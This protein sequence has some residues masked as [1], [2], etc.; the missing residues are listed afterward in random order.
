[1]QPKQ[2]D[3][4]TSLRFLAAASVVVAHMMGS[5]VPPFFSGAPLALGVSFFFVLSGF[6][7]TYAYQGRFDARR[8]Y[9]S[10]FARLWPVHIVTGLLAFVLLSPFLAKHPEWLAPSIANVLLLHAWVPVVGYVFSHNAVS[11]SI[12]AEMF[13]YLL[14]PV[15]RGR[16]L[17]L[18][19]AAT[20]LGTATTLA[21]LDTVPIPQGQPNIWSF[22]P[23]NLVLQHPV[24][25]LLEFLVGI[26]TC[27]LYLSSRNDVPF[28]TIAEAGALISILLFGISSNGIAA[29]LTRYGWRH[30]GMWISQTGGML[31]FA[32]TIFIFAHQRGR[33]SVLLKHRTIVWLGEISFCTY[34]A[35]QIII[36]L[37]VKYSVSDR[38]GWIPASVL[39]LA[40]VYAASH[41][42]WRYWELPARLRILELTKVR[43]A[44]T[45]SAQGSFM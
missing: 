37:F 18:A 43:R 16:W 26:A 15:V 14:F 32:V 12:S 4:L 22:S 1:M 45:E 7:L 20:I 3:T 9:I 42:L 40:T 31:L 8:F 30:V 17:K 39:V 38:L 11:W 2:I 33:I 13:F 23:S 34:M 10:R 35:H 19:F 41:I 24:M 6:I 28:A 27:R 21:V 44:S 5:I 25:R 36:R 29:E